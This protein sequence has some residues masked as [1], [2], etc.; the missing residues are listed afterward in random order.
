MTCPR[1]DLTS[2]ETP[3]IGSR[4]GTD[5]A[6]AYGRI[7]S[8]DEDGQSL[9]E[10]RHD[11]NLRENRPSDRHAGA[12][13]RDDARDKIIYG[14]YARRMPG[15]AEAPLMG[16]RQ[17]S[18]CISISW[19]QLMFHGKFDRVSARLVLPAHAWQGPELQPARTGGADIL[20]GLRRH[21]H[22]A[23]VAL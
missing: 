7:G 14:E 22:V 23:D 2:R 20:D 21:V 15:Q 13:D 9:G 1:P 11:L 17:V 4:S 5:A 19:R 16:E 8:I 10:F 3:R 18:A 6:I 12:S